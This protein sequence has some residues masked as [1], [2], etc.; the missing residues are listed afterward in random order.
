MAHSGKYLN[1]S[2]GR[3]TPGKYQ[4]VG[5]KITLSPYSWLRFHFLIKRKSASVSNLFYHLK[6]PSSLFSHPALRSVPFSPL[7]WSFKSRRLGFQ[8]EDLFAEDED[9]ASQSLRR[10]LSTQTQVIR[11]V[12]EHRRMSGKCH[13]PWYQ[14]LVW[15]LRPS[16]NNY[17]Y[18]VKTR[19][20][21]CSA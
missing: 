2:S 19:P 21:S 9:L 7:P 12:G 16:P 10:K 14:F 17:T 4:E 3:I 6:H 8:D 13:F 5:G 15:A 18:P 20:G 11:P 1:N